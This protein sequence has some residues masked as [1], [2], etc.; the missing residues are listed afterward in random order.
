[1]L[2]RQLGADRFGILALVWVVI[3]YF[4]VFD[5]GLGRAMTQLVAE[6]LG[7]NAR[8]TVPE[9]VRGTLLLTMALGLVGAAGLGCIAPWLVTRVLNIPP[10]LVDESLHA[11]YLLALSVPLVICSVCLRGVLEAHQRFGQVNVVRIPLGVWTFV[12]PL[13]ALLVSQSLVPIVGVLLIGRVV[14]CAAYAGLALR[15]TGRG[16]WRRPEP[17]VLQ[18]LF[19]FGGW[20]TV[21]NLVG[22]LLVYLDRILIGSIMSMSAVT[23]YATPYEVAS[24]LSFIPAG[25]VGV[26]FPALAFS[27]SHDRSQTSKIL[28]RGLDGA[29]LLVLP[30]TIVLS[31]YATPILRWWVGDE[32]AQHGSAVLRW[33][34]IGVFL[35]SLGQMTVAQLQACGRPDLSAKLHLAELVPY[36]IALWWMTHSWG[37]EGAAIAWTLRVGV[38]FVAS[39]GIVAAVLPDTRGALLRSAGTAVFGAALL[40]GAAWAG[41]HDHATTYMAIALPILFANAWRN[42]LQ[43]SDRTRIRSWMM[44]GVGA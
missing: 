26:L 16:R 10:A 35:N 34:P 23:H 32:I 29:A 21:T 7:S 14:A 12:G 6:R 20:M 27:L 4:G 3:G 22:P 44:R 42:L 13:G 11:F 36:G 31:A 15:L 1:M 18:R 2:L 39:A 37:I 30:L 40:V 5:F 28:Q 38:D 33:L 9:I 17:A 24:R 41:V 25:L 8:N 43:V 19:A